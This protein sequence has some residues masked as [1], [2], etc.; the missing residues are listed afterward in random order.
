MIPQIKYFKCHIKIQCSAQASS[1]VL[2]KISDGTV[3]TSNF[4]LNWTVTVTTYYNFNNI[5]EKNI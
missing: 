5:F 2:F 1:G 4:E 3:F